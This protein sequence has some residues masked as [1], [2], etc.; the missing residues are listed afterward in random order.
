MNLKYQTQQF[1]L[2]TVGP[3]VLDLYTDKDSVKQLVVKNEG[4]QIQG[5]TGSTW[6][7]SETTPA[8]KKV[9]AVKLTRTAPSDSTF[10]DYGVRIIK[11]YKTPAYIDNSEYW[12]NGKFYGSVYP[13]LNV[14][15]GSYSAADAL[16]MQ[17]VIVDT[18]NGDKGVSRAIDGAAVNA[19]YAYVVTDDV[20]TDA[21]GFTVTK[22][23]GTTYVFATAST[24]AAGQLA[25]QFNADANVNTILKAYRI[26]ADKYLITSIDN[27][28][29]FT[30]GTEVDTTI[31]DRI[32]L[33]DSKVD[34]ILFDVVVDKTYATVV[35]YHLVDLYNASSFNAG[36]GH[37]QFK[38]DVIDSTNAATSL[39]LVESSSYDD[40]AEV[41]A[42]VVTDFASKGVYATTFG[43]TKVLIGAEEA[44]KNVKVSFPLWSS[45]GQTPYP[46]VTTVLY[47]GTKEGAFSSLTADDVQRI[48]AEQKHAGM[49]ATA[50]RLDQVAASVDYVKITLKASQSTP[51]IHGASH[52]DNYEPTAELYIPKAA[53]RATAAAGT[54]AD[55]W[56]GT[57]ID[58][59]TS[60][61]DTPT[62]ALDRTLHELLLVWG[63][64]VS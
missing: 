7:W 31:E 41:A 3:L 43:A 6:S 62:G 40:S 15:S 19:R 29:D 24:F 23:D 8:V 25:I 46:V 49:L 21:S 28:Y 11:R 1:H 54:G 38:L 30:L 61:H 27:G 58:S 20:N 32:M 60:L 52:R 4:F 45:N 22:A 57:D 14:S 39:T 35:G 44:V 34:D 16:A 10:Y 55:L 42:K 12:P 51:A 37:L 63:T 26:G 59:P 50:I 36:D 64:K 18:I 2:P 53:M 17:K 33:F 47:Q 5:G 56:D 9:K 13:A 48:F